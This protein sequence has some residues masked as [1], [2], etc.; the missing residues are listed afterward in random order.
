M[1][2]DAPLYKPPRR[3]IRRQLRLAFKF[4]FSGQEIVHDRH[5]LRTAAL[6]EPGR[7]VNVIITFDQGTHA[8]GWWR[9][10]SAVRI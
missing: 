7:L 6:T 8:S 3:D 5:F 10:A 9:W 1:S 4:P 2:I